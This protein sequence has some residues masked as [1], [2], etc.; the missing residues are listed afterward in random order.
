VPAGAMH[1]VRDREILAA[2]VA[3]L[4]SIPKRTYLAGQKREAEH[5]PHSRKGHDSEG[6]DRAPAGCRDPNEAGVSPAMRR[7]PVFANLGTGRLQILSKHSG[8]SGSAGGRLAA[9]ARERPRESRPLGRRLLQVRA[10]QQSRRRD[11]LRRQAAARMARVA[12]AGAAWTLRRHRAACCTFEL[13][14]ASGDV[15]T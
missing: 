6:V 14:P 5:V 1:L 15:R 2:R 11:S 7:G 9:P 10:E 4:R 13:S 12:G 3:G 8:Q